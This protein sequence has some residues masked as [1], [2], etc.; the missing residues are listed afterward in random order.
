MITY[1]GNLTVEITFRVFAINSYHTRTHEKKKHFTSYI[2]WHPCFKIY[3][4]IRRKYSLLKMLLSKIAARYI[5]HFILHFNG[6][7]YSYLQTY[8]CNRLDNC[9][10][11]CE[12]KRE[13]LF[14]SA[15]FT[16]KQIYNLYT[17]ERPLR[18]KIIVV[19]SRF[20]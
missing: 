17:Y 16:P 11:I 9:L 15:R 18:N 8:T 1:L 10:F 14:L 4:K 12:N 3:K 6:G 20:S 2:R 13:I 5:R 19:N 7:T